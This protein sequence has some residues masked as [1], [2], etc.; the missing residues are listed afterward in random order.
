LI[1]IYN[2]IGFATDTGQG[3]LTGYIEGLLGAEA[4]NEDTGGYG[5]LDGFKYN[6]V[7]TGPLIADTDEDGISDHNE[8]YDDDNLINIDE[9]ELG[10]TA[11]VEDTDGD[12][13]IDGDEVHIHGTGPLTKDTDGDGLDDD[14]EI[15]LGLN[16][17]N[18]KSDG[19]TPDGDRRF[20]QVADDSIKDD[21]LLEDD[22]MFQPGVSGNVPGDISRNV[23]LEKGQ[24]LAFNDNPTALSEI[25]KLS[26]SYED[27]PLT[28][29]F[30]YGQEYTDD[31]RKLSIISIN[32][33]NE[34]ELVDTDFDATNKIASAEI[35]GDGIYFIMDIDLYLRSIGIDLFANLDRSMLSPE[36]LSDIDNYMQNRETPS[37]IKEQIEEMLGLGNNKVNLVFVL[38]FTSIGYGTNKA[39][40]TIVDF[41]DA[42]ENNYDI[43][44]HYSLIAYDDV[45]HGVVKNGLSNWYTSQEVDLA[46]DYWFDPYASVNDPKPPMRGGMAEI[47]LDGLEVA[48]GLDWRNNAS[49]LVLLVSEDIDETSSSNISD[50]VDMANNEE[51]SISVLG[52]TVVD[53]FAPIYEGTGGILE[54]L[55]EPAST[56]RLETWVMGSLSVGSQWVVLFDGHVSKLSDKLS[57]AATNDTDADGLT[58]AEELGTKT[59]GSWVNPFSDFMGE[60]FSIP[61]E[62]VNNSSLN[63]EVFNAKSYP[64]NLDSDFDGLP[65]GKRDYDGPAIRRDPLPLNNEFKGFFHYKD[66]AG[67][68][69]TKNK[70]RFN[71]D[72]SQFFDKNTTYNQKLAVLGSISVIEMYQTNFLDITDGLSEEPS[73][74]MP[75]YMVEGLLDNNEKFAEIFG[76]KDIENFRLSK[77]T[78]RDYSLSETAFKTIVDDVTEFTI[79]HRLVKNG[80]GQTR[81]I[82][83]VFFR[84]TNGTSAEWSSNFDVGANT[85]NYYN[86]MGNT[87]L[88]ENKLN[89]KGFDVA[90]TRSL[91]K[92]NKYLKDN[93]LDA[94]PYNKSIFI[95]GHSR[96][97]AIANLIG[98]EFEN[99]DGY[100]PFTY[101]FATPNNT[102]DP[103]VKNSKTIFNIVNE[104]DLVPRIAPKVWGFDKYGQTRMISVA[105]SADSINSSHSDYY[106]T[107]VS[108]EWL[109]NNL[110]YDDNGNVLN[111]EDKFGKL[112]N[113]REEMYILDETSEGEVDF[114][115]DFDLNPVYYDTEEE[116]NEAIRNL[117]IDLDKEKLS[118]FTSGKYTIK[119][120]IYH[121]YYVVSNI[122]PAYVCQTIANLAS[123]VGAIPGRPLKGKYDAARWSFIYSSGQGDG[124]LQFGGMFHPHMPLTYY[125]I[126]TND[127]FTNIE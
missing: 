38:N 70:V 109:T 17:N 57:N 117:K 56:T 90:A 83:M 122:Y 8:D 80:K 59:I 41:V 120:N 33:N 51:I 35:V 108:F 28:L 126:S 113:N 102:T 18:P 101:G 87:T 115:F 22:S 111:T 49:K 123:E 78:A 64:D 125:I 84:G 24:S 100:L 44:I 75:D 54:T 26:T 110:D 20:N 61:E 71:F 13:L 15:K 114:D 127:K 74:T 5:L 4:G 60:N 94:S 65:D 92:I 12:T 32:E 98:K 79:G 96:G 99:K 45:N 88:W 95:T 27:I 10:T 3:G 66:S 73:E 124:V 81:E 6:Y 107:N 91:I 68:T 37:S 29:T 43:D 36:R 77:D 89:H 52:D 42:L 58:D 55:I 31:I 104:D 105:K 40:N 67:Q 72:Y 47:L 86:R 85:T 23:I 34:P 121:G 19:S 21:F 11:N 62:S 50:M 119:K 97:A 30:E 39:I 7:D 93:G 16:P 1:A 46:L 25:I 103:N 63:T 106:K 82:I 14:E 118:K 69:K 2:E 9:Q 53:S 76:L 116:A 112:V 48:S